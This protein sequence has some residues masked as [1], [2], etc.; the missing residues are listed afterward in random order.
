VAL[1]FWE[2]ILGFVVGSGT[3]VSDK[4]LCESVVFAIWI[5]YAVSG[6]NATIWYAK[7]IPKLK[8]KIE[9]I[10]INA[11]VDSSVFPNPRK[12]N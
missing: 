12:S 1:W 4:K 8:K 5:W 6:Y 2:E 3:A 11:R 9:E 7:S 10:F